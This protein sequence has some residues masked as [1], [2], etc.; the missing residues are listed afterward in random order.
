[1]TAVY[2]VV[3]TTVPTATSARQQHQ[4]LRRAA[5]MLSQSEHAMSSEKPQNRPS[6]HP[7]RFTPIN[8]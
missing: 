4:A 2:V 5:R 7:L 8:I 1:M 3:A 6:R